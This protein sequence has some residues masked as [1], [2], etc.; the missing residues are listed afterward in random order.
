MSGKSKSGQNCA[1]VEYERPDEAWGAE[2]TVIHWFWHGAG[3]IVGLAAPIGPRSVLI[4]DSRR[5][6]CI[7]CLQFMMKSHPR[8]WKVCSSSQDTTRLA[9]H[10]AR[11]PSC[12]HPLA[13]SILT[14]SCFSAWMRQFQTSMR[15]WLGDWVGVTYISPIESLYNLI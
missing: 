1:F 8:T 6:D 3:I 5:S 12:Y 14:N 11:M 2:A 15:H 9:T 7:S 13:N 4:G 10:T